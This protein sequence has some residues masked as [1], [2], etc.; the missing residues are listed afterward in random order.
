MNRVRIELPLGCEGEE[1]VQALEK[2][3]TITNYG[4]YSD[5]IQIDGCL[6]CPI[7]VSAKDEANLIAIAVWEVNGECDVHVHIEHLH[8]QD[9]LCDAE[10][11]RRYLNE[12]AMFSDDE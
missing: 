4:R 5:C 10:D 3:L 6:R 7:L 8:Y 12:A 1:T 9:I 11:G 2:M